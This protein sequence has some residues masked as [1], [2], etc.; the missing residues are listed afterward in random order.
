MMTDG[1]ERRRQEERGGLLQE[2]TGGGSIPQMGIVSLKS[3]DYFV[4]S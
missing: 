4:I 1:E 2:A 3:N